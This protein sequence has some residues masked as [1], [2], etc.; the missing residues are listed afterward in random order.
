MTPFGAYKLAP[1]AD[2]HW[3]VRQMRDAQQRDPKLRLFTLDYWNA[4]DPRG[5]ARIYARR[6]AEE[7]VHPICRNPRSNQHRHRAM[8]RHAVLRRPQLPLFVLVASAIAVALVLAPHGRELALLRL[9]AGDSQGAVSALQGMVAAGDRSP[10]TLSALAHA[11]AQ[12][13]DNAAAAQLLEGL[14]AVRPGNRAVLETLAGLQRDAG[15]ASGLIST[16]Q[17]LQ[18]MAPKVEW[19]RELA[20]LLGDAGRM[21]DRRARLCGHS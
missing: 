10:A 14:I 17:A 5:I 18:S 21:E 8:I 3:Q 2:Y 20:R 4:D 9:A 13:G 15:R 16:L 7:R 19:Q 12:A 1:E 11:L 6:R